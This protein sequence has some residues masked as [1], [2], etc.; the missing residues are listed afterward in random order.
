MLRSGWEPDQSTGCRDLS[1]IR[2]SLP[3]VGVVE[4]SVALDGDAI[5]VTGL[6][7][8]VPDR[9]VLGAAVVPEG[10]RVLT[11]LEA[12]VV[13]G[14]RAVPEQEREQGVALG[15]GQVLDARREPLVHVE[16]GLAGDRVGADDGVLGRRVVAVAE[17]AR[18]VAPPVVLLAFVDGGQSGEKVLHPVRQALVGGVHAGEERVA[19]AGRH[20]DDTQHARHRRLD[21]AAEGHNDV[22]VVGDPDQAIYGWRGAELANIM[23]FQRDFPAARRIDLQFAYRSSARLLE[24]ATAMIRHNANRLDHRLGSANPP[25]L[26]PAVHNA[27]DPTA[28]AS[29]AVSRAA[30][31]IARDNGSVAILYRTN[32]QS[33]AFETAFKR[34]GIPYRIT[35]DKSFYDRPEIGDALACLQA[36]SNPDTDDEAMRRFVDLPPHP[37]TG[38]KAAAQIDRMRAP[39]FWSRA[40]LA[41]RTGTLPDRHTANLRLRFELAAVLAAVLA[42]AARRLPLDD[43]VDIVLHETGY[44]QAVAASGDPDAA[45][46][47]DNLAELGFDA[48]VFRR[49]AGQTDTAGPDERLQVLAEFLEHCRSM[50]APKRAGAADIRVTLST[51]HGAKGLEFDTVVIG[52]FDAEHLPHRGTLASADDN[53][54]AVEEERRLAYVGMTRARSELYLSVPAVTAGTAHGSAPPSHRRS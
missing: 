46:R 49:D 3:A 10:D 22:F 6:G 2:N 17:V 18:A 33:R 48:A 23:S 28:E 27:A 44:H 25:G 14:L 42:A 31:R 40:A 34:A 47:L 5:A 30:A 37:R 20:L 24:A 29:F 39:T 32:A 45:D 15:D 4:R 50:R 9:Q 41:V 8:V 51:L 26:P 53:R 13:V 36:A 12:A 11:P 7:V 35:G 54:T 16:R 38:Q 19:A 43:L 21:V 52:G 1:P